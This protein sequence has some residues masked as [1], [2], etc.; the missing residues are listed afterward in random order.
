MKNNFN[1]EHLIGKWT[2]DYSI[3]LGKYTSFEFFTNNN[4]I[5]II[6]KFS[7]YQNFLSSR[8]QK[9]VR[10]EFVYTF[11]VPFEID[12][13]GIGVEL[14]II[15]NKFI[16]KTSDGRVKEQLFT[17]REGENAIYTVGFLKDL[18]RLYI[19]VKKSDGNG[20]DPNNRVTKINQSIYTEF[21][22]TDSDV[23]YNYINID[24]DVWHHGNPYQ[25]ELLENIPEEWKEAVIAK[26]NERKNKK[27]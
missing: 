10:A 25:D 13:L 16:I 4:G 11:G 21:I 1:K 26:R 27:R 3:H 9:Q 19:G 2:N 22:K 17:E 18:T 15:C 20:G 8:I 12:G 6:N 7:N 14:N 23:S 24:G 5:M